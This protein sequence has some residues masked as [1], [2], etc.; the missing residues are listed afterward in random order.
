MS[1][2]K[3]NY[4]RETSGVNPLLTPGSVLDLNKGVVEDINEKDLEV[5]NDKANDKLVDL[6][7]LLTNKINK[8]DH[9][10]T[11]SSTKASIN[12]YHQ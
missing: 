9:K 8:K 11:R 3:E 10:A 7:S 4:G 2:E 6:V 1:F 12:T 5:E